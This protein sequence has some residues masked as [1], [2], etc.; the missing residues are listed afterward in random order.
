VCGASLEITER[1]G[2]LKQIRGEEKEILARTTK[3][4]YC[5]AK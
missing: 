1:L 5:L 4:L 3:K 2:L